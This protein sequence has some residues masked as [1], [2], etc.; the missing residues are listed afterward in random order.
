M[1]IVA[2]LLALIAFG[3]LLWRDR[4]IQEQIEKLREDGRRLKEASRRRAFYDHEIDKVLFGD[5]TQA[6]KQMV[7]PVL[8]RMRDDDR[9]QSSQ[10]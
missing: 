7:V 10:N 4:D 8:Q 1:K 3:V 6:Y 5:E 2:P 9:Q